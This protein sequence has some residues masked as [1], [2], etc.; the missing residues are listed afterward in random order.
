[1]PFVENPPVKVY[2][3]GIGE[4]VY[5]DSTTSA[6]E[7]LSKGT[8]IRR[9]IVIVLLTIVAIVL[10]WL[11]FYN[12]MIWAILGSLTAFGFGWYYA[13]V[14]RFLGR[15][16]FIGTEGFAVY[17]FSGRRENVDWKNERR[18]EE[19]LLLLHRE[20]VIFNNGYDKTNYAFLLMKEPVEGGDVEIIDEDTSY[21]QCPDGGDNTGDPMYDFWVR[22]EARMTE[23]GV[24]DAKARWA[25]GESQP[26]YIF[27]KEDDGSWKLSAVM[28]L[29]S[30][31]IQLEGKTFTREETRLDVNV[32]YLQKS[33]EEEKFTVSLQTT[34]N[35][36]TLRAL[37]AA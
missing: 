31:S 22:V 4:L 19:K 15:D 20:E 26:F 11:L 33:G 14:Q 1:M 37:L 35:A 32:L 8:Y 23:K 27:K 30:D 25:T 9:K 13:R 5:V 16:F 7:P 2:P 28:Q 3:E 18:F 6:E 17:Q 36:P 29:F 21:H 12:E 24:R 10:C 34:G